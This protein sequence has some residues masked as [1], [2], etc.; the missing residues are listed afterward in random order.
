MKILVALVLANRFLP[1][2]VQSLLIPNKLPQKKKYLKCVEIPKADIVT[3]RGFHRPTNKENNKRRKRQNQKI[4][5]K[6]NNM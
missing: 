5:K 4:E 2:K 3:K 1:P 6:E